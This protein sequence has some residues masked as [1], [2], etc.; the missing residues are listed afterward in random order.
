MALLSL[1]VL[2]SSTLP[3]QGAEKPLPHLTAAETTRS[4]IAPGESLPL[5]RAVSP[6]MSSRPPAMPTPAE[7][8]PIATAATASAALSPTPAPVMKPVA[9]VRP[10]PGPVLASGV[11]LAPVSPALVMRLGS[12]PTVRDLAFAPDGHT[13]VSADA[14]GRVVSWDTDS[15]QPIAQCNFPPKLLHLS[16]DGKM[17]AGVV[18]PRTAVA[19]G[20]RPRQSV[21]V[22]KVRTGQL[23]SALYPLANGQLIRPLITTLTFSPD[24]RVLAIA[25]GSIG[26]SEV[27][28]WDISTGAIMSILPPLAGDAGL[29]YGVPSLAFSP[30]G[31]TLAVSSFVRPEAV[32]DEYRSKTTPRLPVPV[33]GIYDIMG[34][35]WRK[36]LPASRSPFCLSPDGSL[37]AA[38][39]VDRKRVQVWEV[40]TG[41]KLRAF[42]SA[43]LPTSPVGFAPDGQHLWCDR[44]G[45]KLWNV[46]SGALT[47]QVPF[48]SHVSKNTLSPDGSFLARGFDNGTVEI[49]RLRKP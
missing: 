26:H 29:S 31:G 37:L 8:L 1:L 30:D 39:T 40:A 14:D 20:S 6:P 13:V 24:G 12:D 17:V 35:Q 41:K 2:G 45:L 5:P 34:K 21:N 11:T 43:S 36:T 42:G 16:E 27:Q 44:S 15:R 18:M 3:G 46:T 33:V 48:N 47:I 32:A 28:L 38:S 22:A 49:W 10:A 7:P 23:I 9:P 19:T 25:V 4:R